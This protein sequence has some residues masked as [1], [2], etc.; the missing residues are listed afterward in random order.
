MGVNR[1]KRTSG[2]CSPDLL[3]DARSDE[4]YHREALIRI[5]TGDSVRMALLRIVRSIELLDCWIGAGFVRNC[6]WDNLHGHGIAAPSGDIDV[7]Y[8]D[9]TQISESGDRRIEARLSQMR[10][11]FCWS[12]KNQARMHTR[13]GDAPYSSVFHAMQFWPET[14]TAV[15]VRLNGQDG[16]DVCAPYG[17]GDLFQL[18]LKPTPGF[19]NAKRHIFDA[20]VASKVWLKSYP[21]LKLDQP[22]WSR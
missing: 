16:L 19:V 13:N 20:R 22:T 4:A 21:L 9:P 10:P 7:I 15:A 2:G 17:L 14:A 3:G 8:Y 5:I 6:I 12:V 1:I 11:D 18:K